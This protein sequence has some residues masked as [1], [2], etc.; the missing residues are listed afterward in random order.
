MDLRRRL[1]ARLL[2]ERIQV[3]NWNEA[4]AARKARIQPK[5]VRRIERGLNYEMASL[6]KYAAALGYQLEWWLLE[7]LREDPPRAEPTPAALRMGTS[8]SPE[9]A[10]IVNRLEH[11]AEQRIPGIPTPQNRQLKKKL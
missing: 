7:I 3:K 4:A 11:Q 10:A 9:Q 8:L 6:E 5:T 1:G 2:T